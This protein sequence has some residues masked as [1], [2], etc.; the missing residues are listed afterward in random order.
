[1]ELNEKA[2]GISYYASPS[3]PPEGRLM[4]GWVIK[5]Y[6]KQ[7]MGKIVREKFKEKNK[8]AFGGGKKFAENDDERIV[9]TYC[10][11]A[12]IEKVIFKLLT[13]GDKLEMKLMA[14]VPSAIIQDIFEEN[15]KEICMSQWSVN[16]KGIRRKINKRC[17]AIIS[18]MITNN[19]LRDKK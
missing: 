9:A 17:L 19:T 3:A 12:R 8:E 7:I 14:K 4:E 6:D 18:Q 10:T 13:E 16:F 5:N 11:N 1:M 15:W 2:F